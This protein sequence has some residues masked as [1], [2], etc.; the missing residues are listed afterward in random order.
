M[1][2]YVESD[3]VVLGGL[4]VHG[5]RRLVDRKVSFY[6]VLVL[7]GGCAPN[8]INK[9]LPQVNVGVE[10]GHTSRTLPLCESQYD[11]AC[12]ELH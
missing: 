2:F 6:C 12:H 5:G 7:V 11:K 1:P 4:G 10:G 9:Y 3:G 8:F